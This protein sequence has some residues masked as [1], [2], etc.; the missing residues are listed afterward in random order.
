MGPDCGATFHWYDIISQLSWRFE[1]FVC[2]E[3]FLFGLKSRSQSQGLVLFQVQL[4]IRRL[5]N[6]SLLPSKLFEA[7]LF[8]NNAVTVIGRSLKEFR[9]HKKLLIKVINFLNKCL[10]WQTSDIFG[11]VSL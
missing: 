1:L 6:F 4:S 7:E 10:P 2:F 8:C 3:L 9:N 5:S 11:E